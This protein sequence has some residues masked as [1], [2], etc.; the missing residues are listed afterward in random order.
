ME[1]AEGFAAKDRERSANGIEGMAEDSD[2]ALQR[3]EPLGL[4]LARAAS[5]PARVFDNNPATKRS[6]YA[7]KRSVGNA[8]CSA[9]RGLRKKPG[10]W[11]NPAPS[12][13]THPIAGSMHH[14]HDN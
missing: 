7:V 14:H 9:R 6:L 5:L 2:R 1:N 10:W 12:L 11:A 13:M 4:A 3:C 8:V